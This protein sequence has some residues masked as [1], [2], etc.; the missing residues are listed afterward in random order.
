MGKPVIDYINVAL[1]C[2]YYKIYQLPAAAFT[3]ALA[4]YSNIC[5]ITEAAAVAQ[6]QRSGLPPGE[7]LF[8]QLGLSWFEVTIGR[9]STCTGTNAKEV[10]VLKARITF[11]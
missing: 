11:N 1:H 10:Q 4:L 9:W 7:P 3:H 5:Y 6:W 8:N 2:I